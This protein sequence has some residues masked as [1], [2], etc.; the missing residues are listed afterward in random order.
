[1]ISSNAFATSP[2]RHRDPVRRPFQLAATALIVAAVLAGAGCGAAEIDGRGQSL[3]LGTS[4]TLAAATPR[5]VDRF[6]G[7]DRLVT[8]EYAQNNPREPDAIVSP[9][10]DVTSGSLFV[11]DGMGWTGPP[12]HESPSPDSSVATGSAVFRAFP[13]VETDGDSVVSLRLLPIGFV[14]D[15]NRQ[16]WDGVHVLTRVRS[17]AEFY[18]VSVLRRDGLIA[19]KRKLPG[20][21]SN[22]GTYVTLASAEVPTAG[23]GWHDIRV[24]TTD[25]NGTVRILLWLDGV[26]VLEAI[27]A[28]EFAPPITGPSGIGIRGDNIEFTIDDLEVR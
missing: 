4:T 26:V 21:P 3:D 24:D 16:D 5:F 12:D 1:M 8:N 17:D 25:R 10:W 28:G 18:S 20:G 6:E 27:D 23:D 2:T 7:S 14:D 15:S 22:G 19:I 11:R 13:R 9:A